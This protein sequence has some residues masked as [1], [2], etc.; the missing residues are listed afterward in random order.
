MDVAAA[1]RQNR[2]EADPA[3]THKSVTGERA[4]RKVLRPLESELFRL[5]QEDDLLERQV[6]LANGSRWV[7]VK[8]QD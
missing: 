8:I 1:V 7:P 4:S 5:S 6:A 2:D 3:R